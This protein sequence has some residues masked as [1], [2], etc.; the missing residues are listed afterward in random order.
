GW[1]RTWPPRAHR[2]LRFPSS[3]GPPARRRRRRAPTAT[4]PGRRSPA[5]ARERIDRSETP[6]RGLGFA[7]RNALEFAAAECLAQFD[8]RDL[9]PR[10]SQ[11]VVV[12]AERPMAI[13][14]RMCAP[15]G[16]ADETGA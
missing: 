15:P 12:H 5:T 10:S 9:Q 11:L 1:W 13:I 14:P 2:V 4:D 3:R 7:T 16:Q 6:L 8:H